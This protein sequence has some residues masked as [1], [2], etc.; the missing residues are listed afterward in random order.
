MFNILEK[1]AWGFYRILPRALVVSEKIIRSIGGFGE[2]RHER[3]RIFRK[4]SRILEILKKVTGALEIFG[5][6]P[7]KTLK[8]LEKDA[9]RRKERGG[10]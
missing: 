2:N 3:W 8:S 9:W 10:R 4:S 7:P 1:A 5:E 6:G